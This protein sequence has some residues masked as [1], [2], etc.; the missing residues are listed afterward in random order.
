MTERKPPGMK[1]EDWVEAQIRRAQN[2]GEFDDLPG[3]GKPIPK[4]ADPHDADWWV[5][6][7]LRREKIEADVLLPPAMLLRK[8]KQRIPETVEKFRTEREVRDYLEDLNKRILVNIRDSTG[9]VVPVGQV[10]EEEVVRQ[11]RE[12]RPTPKPA[13]RPSSQQP[14]RSIWQRLFS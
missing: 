8:E 3:T 14:K 7:F 13:P 4:L 10:D 2:Q 9:P 1:T 12:R 6:D 5:K 11:W